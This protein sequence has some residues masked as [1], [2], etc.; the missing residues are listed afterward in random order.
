MPKREAGDDFLSLSLS[1]LLS[2][3][4]LTSPVLSI[5]SRWTP[6]VIRSLAESGGVHLS[7]ESAGDADVLSVIFFY[8]RC[9]E[10]E[11]TSP[12]IILIFVSAASSFPPRRH[13][14]LSRPVISA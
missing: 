12:E 6:A 10:T 3:R 13:Q 4:P 2:R 11:R 14:C 1:F 9:P 7:P 8:S 5:T